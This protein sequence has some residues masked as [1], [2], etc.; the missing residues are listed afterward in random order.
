MSTITK[1]LINRQYET[2]HRFS[3]CILNNL[4]IIHELI[5]LIIIL[6]VIL[7]VKNDYKFKR[8]TSNT[9]LQI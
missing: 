4:I 2:G 7:F 9:S 8:A 3:D 1:L 6:K 5:G